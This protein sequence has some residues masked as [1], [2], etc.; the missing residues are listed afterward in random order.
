MDLDPRD[1]TK[2]VEESVRYALQIVGPGDRSL[3]PAAEDE[4][5][6]RPA[7]A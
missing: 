2:R 3:E 1:P 6:E 4:S 7:A 5:A